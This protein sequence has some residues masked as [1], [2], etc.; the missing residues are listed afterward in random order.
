[1][2]YGFSLDC[3]CWRNVCNAALILPNA[4]PNP[5]QATIEKTPPRLLQMRC[6]FNYSSIETHSVSLLINN[7]PRVPWSAAVRP[8]DISV[9]LRYRFRPPFLIPE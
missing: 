8:E 3:R 7:F 5:L 2:D 1:M 6:L 9:L 4:S